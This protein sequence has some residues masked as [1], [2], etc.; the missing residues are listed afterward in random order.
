MYVLA[1]FN[2]FPN[3]SDA[4]KS[5][6]YQTCIYIG[7][8]AIIKLLT[9]LL[10]QWKFWESVKQLVLTP[11][12]NATV[13]LIL[14]MLVIPFFV[15]LL[16]FWVTDNFLMR[17]E[18]HQHRRSFLIKYVDKFSRNGGQ[19]NGN[20]GTIHHNGGV[21]MGNGKFGSN[22]S[23]LLERAQIYCSQKLNRRFSENEHFYTFTE[24]DLNC[25]FNE[26]HENND[27][28]SDALISGDERFD[29]ELT[30]DDCVALDRAI[31]N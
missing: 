5:W 13:E 10:I 7:L 20:A 8:M 30:D 31:I 29:V 27:S 2:H 21:N 26:F 25:N 28:E 14:F 9:T 18:H 23:T 12:S 15:N 19:S 1:E 17:H 3:I 6:I 24:N 11:F 22:R 4:P 16:I